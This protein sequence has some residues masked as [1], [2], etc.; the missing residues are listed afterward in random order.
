MFWSCGCETRRDAVRDNTAVVVA[1]RISGRW[2]KE[3][4]RRPAGHRVRSRGDRVRVA[5]CSRDRRGRAAQASS[6][7]AG[8]FE[9][10]RFAPRTSA[11]VTSA[12]LS[13][14]MEGW[15]EG[16][17]P[18]SPYPS[19]PPSA[20]W[21]RAGAGFAAHHDSGSIDPRFEDLDVV[22]AVA[23]VTAARALA[24]VFRRRCRSRPSRAGDV[25]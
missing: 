3:S 10:R 8:G 1:S 20:S 4:W 7:V 25:Q 23:I 18:L 21:P 14:D 22:S 15:A 17:R 6:R 19:I 24:S 12:A 9:A 16:L 2:R 13:P 11:T 5:G